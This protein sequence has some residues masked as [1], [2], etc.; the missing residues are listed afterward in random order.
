ML[1]AFLFPALL[2]RLGTGP[3]LA[4]LAATSLLG[5]AVTWWFR[6]ETRGLNLERL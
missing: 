6:I 1:T 4:A 5:A 2:Q 3:L